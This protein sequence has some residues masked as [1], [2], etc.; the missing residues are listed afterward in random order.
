MSAHLDG[1]RAEVGAR[2]EGPRAL[3]GLGRGVRQGRNLRSR[4][5]PFGLL[6]RGACSLRSQPTTLVKARYVAQ[7]PTAEINR[8]RANLSRKFV[9]LYTVSG[10]QESLDNIRKKPSSTKGIQGCRTVAALYFGETGLAEL[11]RTPF[12]RTSGNSSSETVWKIAEGVLDRVRSVPQDGEMGLL[13]PL[14]PLG[15]G[16]SG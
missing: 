2:A 9:K 5:P 6:T 4:G 12:S 11:L 8:G 14:R 16:E 15:D 3:L 7:A 13:P 1:G 10:S